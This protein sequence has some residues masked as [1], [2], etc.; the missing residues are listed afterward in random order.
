[1]PIATFQPGNTLFKAF[2]FTVTILPCH[3]S[4]V[5]FLKQNPHIGDEP[6]DIE[7]LV[8]IGKDAGP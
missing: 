6:V 2:V 1:M 8:N 7:D 5:E 4:L 3:E